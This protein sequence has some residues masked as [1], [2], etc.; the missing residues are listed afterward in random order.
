ME[1]LQP[2]LWLHDYKVF[3]FAVPSNTSLPNPFSIDLTFQASYTATQTALLL[4]PSAV[5]LLL[6][7][8]RV[9]QLHRASLKVLPNYTG[10]VKAVG[11]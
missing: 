11:C 6:F 2:V 10:A 3:G 1:Y 9:I 7:P 4:I 5:F 8:F